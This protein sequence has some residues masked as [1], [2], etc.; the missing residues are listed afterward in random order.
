MMRGLV[1][2]NFYSVGSTLKWT[3]VF[4]AVVNIFV[5]I[6]GIVYPDLIELL[7]MLMVGQ[8]GA[9]VGLVGTALQKDNASK[10]SKYEKTLPVKACE[11]V[12]ARYISFIMFSAIGII[13]G[14]IS[15]F[16]LAVV[17]EAPLNLERLGFGYSF[18]ITFALLVPSLIYPLIL[19]FGPDKSEM[20]TLVSV[21]AT[22]ALFTGG[23]GLLSPYL[24]D[25]NNA[26]TIYRVSCIAISIIV[27]IAS[28]CISLAIY[29]RRES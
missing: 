5:A 8:V 3:I 28:Y 15:V 17:G 4:C 21:L 9:F 20:L 11:I 7:P 22:V 29:K 13:F 12:R 27:F 2:N 10:W 26:N 6:G 19:K 16:I 24:K 23:S 14:S 25:L 18:G 1:R